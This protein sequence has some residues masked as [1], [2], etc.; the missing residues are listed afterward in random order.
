MDQHKLR[1]LVFEKTG[2]K[3]DTT[4][5]VFAVVA[6]N[7]A[8]L[9]EYV[10]RHVTAM[11]ALS[12]KLDGQTRH[13][14][15]AGERYRKLHGIEESAKLPHAVQVA[16]AEQDIA[17]EQNAAPGFS[18]KKILVLMSGVAALSITLTLLAQW[19]LTPPVRPPIQAV[20]AAP[21]L[22]AKQVTMIR[23]GEKYAKLWPKL[24]AETQAK[25]QALMQ[26]P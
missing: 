7:E 22:S 17:S 9:E 16:A 25:I 4:D 11:N 24:D 12:N 2:I 14:I 26:Q 13:L 6:L 5:P 10:E 1:T 18:S 15:E 20:Q 23:N 8:V 3:V 21:T 19:T